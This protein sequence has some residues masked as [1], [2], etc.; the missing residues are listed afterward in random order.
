MNTIN[1]MNNMNNMNQNVITKK[2]DSRCL[3]LE[4]WAEI[5]N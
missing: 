4:F 1:N 3:L 5:L 2:I